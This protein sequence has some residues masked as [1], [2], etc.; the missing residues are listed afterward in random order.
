MQSSTGASGR[1][2]TPADSRVGEL[3]TVYGR[4]YHV[5][6]MDAFTRHHLAEHGIDLA[7][8]VQIHACPYDVHLLCRGLRT[9]E[10][11]K[12]IQMLQREG[13][14]VEVSKL[15]VAVREQAQQLVADCQRLAPIGGIFHLAMILEDR[16]IFKHVSPSAYQQ[17]DRHLPLA[18]CP[19]AQHLGF[20]LKSTMCFSSQRRLHW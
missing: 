5:T 9:G 2:L 12:T 11:M 14:T 1:P 15:D 16:L 7:L 6:A 13:V 18:L 19:F 4:T 17:L 20:R 10:Q 3:A 8:D